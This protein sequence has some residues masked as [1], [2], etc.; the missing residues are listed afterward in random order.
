MG[1][2]E[3]LRGQPVLLYAPVSPPIR[4]PCVRLWPHVF[5]NGKDAI[6]LR[7]FTTEKELLRHRNQVNSTQGPVLLKG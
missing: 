4:P 7:M 2:V 1:L 6:E 5:G 3:C